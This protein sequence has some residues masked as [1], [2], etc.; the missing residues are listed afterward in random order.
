MPVW[1][2]DSGKT[3]SSNPFLISPA[4]GIRQQS[5]LSKLTF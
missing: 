4:L 5:N 3:D 1:L 2:T